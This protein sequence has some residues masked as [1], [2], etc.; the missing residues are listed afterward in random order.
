[1]KVIYN[2]LIPFKGFRAI[3]LFGIVFVR[4]SKELTDSESRHEEIHTWQMRELWYLPF[5]LVYLGEWLFRLLR[6]GNAYREISFEREAYTHENDP[7]Y[8]QNRSRFAQWRLSEN[9]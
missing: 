1:M 9:S 5:Y 2:N 6:K 7:T 4:G 3:N 8:L